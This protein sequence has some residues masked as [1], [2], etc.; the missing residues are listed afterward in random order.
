V[1]FTLALAYSVS[2]YVMWAMGHRGQP[3]LP[4]LPEE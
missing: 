4:V 3:V 2:G 1:L